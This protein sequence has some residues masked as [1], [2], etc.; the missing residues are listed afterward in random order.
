MWQARKIHRYFRQLNL[1]RMISQRDFRAKKRHVSGHPSRVAH[2]DHSNQQ[3]QVAITI[4][5]AVVTLLVSTELLVKKTNGGVNVN[6]GTQWN[7]FQFVW[8]SLA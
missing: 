5:I 6:W 4:A 8:H 2:K 3:C 1:H 7:S